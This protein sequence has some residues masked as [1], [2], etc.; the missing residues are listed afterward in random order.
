MEGETMQILAATDVHMNGIEGVHNSCPERNQR[1]RIIEALGSGRNIPKVEEHSLA[2]YYKYLTEHLRLPFIAHY[3]K[4]TNPE[5]EDGFRC[6]VLKLLDPA[7]HLGDGFDGIFAKTSKGKY[8]LNL[9]LIE[10]E[11]PEN[12]LNFQLI[13]DFWYWFWNWR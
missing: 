11:V 1:Y 4:P 12:S 2:R 13:E 8:E 10:L 9:P 7:M 6:T 5:E 3:P